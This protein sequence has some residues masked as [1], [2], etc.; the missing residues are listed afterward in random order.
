MKSKLT[1]IY[2]LSRNQKFKWRGHKYHQVLRHEKC[3]I[4]Q[5]V[6]VQRADFSCEWI[7]FPSG[8]LVKP[9]VVCNGK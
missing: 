1:P 9:V 4:G 2:K 7:N 6:Y 5:R 8:R 3:K